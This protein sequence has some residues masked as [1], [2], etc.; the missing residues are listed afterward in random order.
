MP[1]P[2]PTASEDKETFLVRCMGDSVMTEEY[3][4]PNQRY[5]VCIQSYNDNK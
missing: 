1:I 5:A 2:K 4:E 3:T